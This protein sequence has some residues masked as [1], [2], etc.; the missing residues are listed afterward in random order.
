[1]K[2]ELKPKDLQ[3]KS[4]DSRGRFTLGSEYA[5][6]EVTVMVVETEGKTGDK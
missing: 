3:T 5:H 1:M 6:K 2:V 4:T